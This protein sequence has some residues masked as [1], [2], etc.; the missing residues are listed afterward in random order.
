MQQSEVVFTPHLTDGAVMRD[1]ISSNVLPSSGLIIS[2][3]IS[4]IKWKDELS[5]IINKKWMKE[6]LINFSHS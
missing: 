2:S 6:K 3:R 4:E 1:N 5:K